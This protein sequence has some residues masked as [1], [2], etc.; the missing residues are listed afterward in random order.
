[1]IVSVLK[2]EQSGASF[3][4]PVSYQSS[5]I[6]NW[7]PLLDFSYAIKWAVW[8][9]DVKV[10]SKMFSADPFDKDKAGFMGSD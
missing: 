1:M 8:F 4:Q 9:G 2:P 5:F 3:I 6:A 10:E 7:L